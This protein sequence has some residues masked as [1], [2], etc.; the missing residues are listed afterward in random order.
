MEN[1]NLMK[2]YYLNYYKYYYLMMKSKQANDFSLCW[3]VRWYKA[4]NRCHIRVS[5]SSHIMINN[6]ADALNHALPLPRTPDGSDGAIEPLPLANDFS[7][8]WCVSGK[9]EDADD[10]EGTSL[11]QCGE[12][13]YNSFSLL[14]RGGGIPVMRWDTVVLK[15]NGGRG[16][17]MWGPEAGDVNKHANDFFICWDVPTVVAWGVGVRC[18]K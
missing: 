9:P 15:Y 2:N 18:G 12:R 7:L 17:G 13:K 3:G 14:C 11:K 16:G 4:G 5:E 1:L 6:T 10:S 8:A